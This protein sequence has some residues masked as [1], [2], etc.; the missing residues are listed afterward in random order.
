MTEPGLE[1]RPYQVDPNDPL[2]TSTEAAEYAGVSVGAFRTEVSR[3]PLLH[4]GRIAIDART[5]RYPTSL[6]A[7]WAADRPGRGVRTPLGA[8]RREAVRKALAEA[9][10]PQAS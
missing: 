10:L 3:N 7:K 6:I 2:L 5:F 1:V 4:D 8:I 9:N